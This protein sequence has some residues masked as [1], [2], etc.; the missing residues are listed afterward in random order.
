MIH[1]KRHIAKTITYRMLGTLTTVII[2][3]IFTKS[4]TIASSVGFI[5]LVIKPVVYFI[6]ER[7]WYKWIKFGLTN[8]GE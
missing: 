8:R 6:H 1:V 2:S 3:Y 5:E 4:L 7:V